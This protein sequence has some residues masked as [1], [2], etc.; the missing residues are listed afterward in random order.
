MV[1]RVYTWL[2]DTSGFYGLLLEEISRRRY[3]EP[4]KKSIRFLTTCNWKASGCTSRIRESVIEI[5][6]YKVNY[7]VG[8]LRPNPSNIKEDPWLQEKY[9]ETWRKKLQQR[10]G[11][12][13]PY[14][15]NSFGSTRYNF[16]LLNNTKLHRSIGLLLEAE[17]LKIWKHTLKAQDLYNWIK[18]RANLYRWSVIDTKGY[19]KTAFNP[20]KSTSQPSTRS[21]ILKPSCT[22][23]STPMN[24]PR[25]PFVTVTHRSDKPYKL[26]PY[27]PVIPMP[28]T[29]HE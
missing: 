12:V 7:T 27:K 9:Q 11:V 28:P 14:N 26:K 6:E 5:L 17:R 16:E 10:K 21:S 4:D 2:D 25:V 3:Q 24:T 29:P 13:Q 22:S 20:S 8:K 1:D 15:R 23:W 19:P 18:H